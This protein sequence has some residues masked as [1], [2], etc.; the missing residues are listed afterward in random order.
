MKKT[1]KLWMSE[2][3]NEGLD[4]LGSDEK[5][6]IKKLTDM[7]EN[8]KL[9][10]GPTDKSKKFTVD[11]PENFLAD[12][13]VHTSNDPIVDK[14][15]VNRVHKILNESSKSFVKI[16]QI[17]K[18]SGH[19]DR[20]MRNMYVQSN[21]EL[22]VLDGFHKDHKPGRKKR[23]LVDGNIGPMSNYSEILSLIIRSYNEEM[24]VKLNGGSS[25]KSTE[26]LLCQRL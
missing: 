8:K 19:I 21:T 10:V 12:M 1:V 15:Y 18:Q 6:G 14:K 4:N 26:E 2:N 20:I 11:K 5:D 16:F 22:P 23:A 9:V 7:I 24:K 17:G 3:K 25:I 13:K